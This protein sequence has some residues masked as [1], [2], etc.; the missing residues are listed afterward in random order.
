MLAQY[1]NKANR[2]TVLG[3]VAQFI[4]FFIITAPAIGFEKIQSVGILLFLGGTVLFIWGC[5]HYA[6][7][8]GYPGTYGSLGILSFLGYLLLAALPDKHK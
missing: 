8:K 4:G 5:C 7:G 6:K 1:K 3:F 2:K